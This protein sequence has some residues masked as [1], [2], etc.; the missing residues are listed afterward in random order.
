[1]RQVRLGLCPPP[2]SQKNLIP[3]AEKITEPESLGADGTE[4]Q[5]HPD[6]VEDS[7][8]QNDE[9]KFRPAEGVENVK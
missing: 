6:N 3:L 1:M 2:F 9:A 8:D 5:Q 4:G 7:E